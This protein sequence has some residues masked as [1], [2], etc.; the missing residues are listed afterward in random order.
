MELK[1]FEVRMGLASS[2]F[3]EV[4]VKFHLYNPFQ[5]LDLAENLVPFYYNS[6]GCFGNLGPDGKFD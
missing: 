6:I 4:L 3:G 2:F 5:C 1:I